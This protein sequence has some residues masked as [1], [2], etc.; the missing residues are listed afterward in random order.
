MRSLRDPDG[1]A[2]VP[3]QFQPASAT[4]AAVSPEAQAAGIAPGE[5]LLAV[6]GRPYEG[7]SDLEAPVRDHHAGE[8]LA[9][10]VGRG[11]SSD[12][13]AARDVSVTLASGAPGIDR[14][15]VLRCGS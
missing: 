15:G 7:R 1:V 10:R 2:R 6:G 9:L 14:R 12:P 11:G 3:L 13:S 5:V 4:I 8:S